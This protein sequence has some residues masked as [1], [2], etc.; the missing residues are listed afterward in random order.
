MTDLSKDT[1]PAGCGGTCAADEIREAID[2]LVRLVALDQP[3]LL[4]RRLDQL[5]LSALHNMIAEKLTQIEVQQQ[6]IAL[7]RR[8]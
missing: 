4:E 5:G 8:N 3:V 2:H 6:H 7:L 1:E